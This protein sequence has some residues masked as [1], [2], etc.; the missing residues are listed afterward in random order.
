MRTRQQ[1]RKELEMPLYNVTVTLE[2]KIVVVADDED[3]AWQVARNEA[4]E[5]IDN[6]RPDPDVHVR[7]E[8][9]SEKHL[10]D[11][12][13]GQCVPYGGD[14]NTRISALLTHNVELTCRRSAAA[15]REPASA[16]CRRSG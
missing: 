3:H 16:A 2:T 15:R 1:K 5:A 10:R 11:G 4:R 12:W 13:D 8:I 7:G 9:T 14:R 6:D